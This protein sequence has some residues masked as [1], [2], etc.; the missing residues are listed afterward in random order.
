MKYKVGDIV[1]LPD[2]RGSNWNSSGKMDRY[3]GRL[4]KIKSIHCD[5][6]FKIHQDE[7]DPKSR[8]HWEFKFDEIVQLCNSEVINEY[9]IY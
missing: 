8:Y 5:Q 6:L 9:Q 7:D 3:L 4:V 1:L 2:K